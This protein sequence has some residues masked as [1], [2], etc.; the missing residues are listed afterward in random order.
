VL[1]N[2]PSIA[3]PTDL[4]RLIHPTLD[5]AWDDDE[6]RWRVKSSAFQNAHDS[7]SM[8]VVLGDTLAASGRQPEDAR[9]SMPDRFVAALTAGEVRHEE[10][11]V[12]RDATPDEPAHG[13][14]VGEK[15]PKRR[16]RFARMA[17]WIVEPPPP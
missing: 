12:V 8:S 10:Q 16:Q 13:N 5:I 11:G 1:P 6:S 2:D 14:V 15:K 3:D 17:R 9:Q 7:D 4:Y